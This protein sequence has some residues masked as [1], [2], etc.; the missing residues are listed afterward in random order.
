MRTALIGTYTLNV[1]PGNTTTVLTCDALDISRCQ[2]VTLE[3]VL[4]T[5]ATDAADKLDVRFQ[6]TRDSQ[7]TPAVWDTR[8]YFTQ[9]SGNQSASASAPYAD[10]MTISQDVPL[11]SS[12]RNARPTGSA[13]GTELTAGTVRDGPFQGRLRSTL[14]PVPS[15]RLIAVISGDVN[16]NSLFVGSIKIYGTVDGNAE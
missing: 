13:G 15:H 7:P 6:E 5:C 12:S 11:P 3:M 4:T 14:G 8:G 1:G 9:V 16:S 10:Q 2:A